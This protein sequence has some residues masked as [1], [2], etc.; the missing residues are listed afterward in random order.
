M[1]I[2]AACFTLRARMFC[3]AFAP[4]HLLL[5]GCFALGACGGKA[6][7]PPPPDKPAKPPPPTDVPMTVGQ[8]NATLRFTVSVQV[9]DAPP[10]DALLD[11]G[12]GGLRLV[13]G[14]VPDSAFTQILS[15]QVQGV[16][17]S[18]LAVNGRI[19]MATVN[20]GGLVTP[21]PIP[22]MHIDSFDCASADPSCNVDTEVM[23][24]FSGFS[25]ILGVGMRNSD[26]TPVVG[27]PIVQ[28]TGQPPFIIEAPP[29]PG[30]MGTLR[31]SPAA[32]ETTGFTPFQLASDT[33][34]LF[35]ANHT[36]AWND[37]EVPTCVN[38][39][40]NG[41]QYC[42]G[43]FYDTGTPF[44]IISLPGQTTM[45]PL[46]A[47]S[48]TRAMAVLRL[49]VAYVRDSTVGIGT[50]RFEDCRGRGCGCWAPCGWSGV[51]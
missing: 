14:A 31:I 25:A 39:K 2:F 32:A 47:L 8:Y 3:L 6:H 20:I 7:T 41:M 1:T 9:G 10:F 33:R 30:G 27:N 36:P 46:P 11:T 21:A 23:S 44:T 24:H 43:G 28:L 51:A 16:F 15:E 26:E 4:R 19:A 17:G 29:F 34:E 50:Y 45:T 35:L 49:P 12:S 48:Q 5:L 13:P 22:V 37:E 42:A 38:D 40:T 18:S